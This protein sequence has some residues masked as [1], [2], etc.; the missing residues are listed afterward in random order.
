MGLWEY[1]EGG[2]VSIDIHR[3]RSCCLVC[4]I[5]LLWQKTWRGIQKLGVK[6][7]EISP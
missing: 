3:R 7:L 2:V 5:N 6:I 4:I 1:D